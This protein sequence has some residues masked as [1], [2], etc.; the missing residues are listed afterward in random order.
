MESERF[1]DYT[2]D[3]RKITDQRYRKTL[4]HSNIAVHIMYD[5]LFGS[6]YAPYVLVMMLLL[7]EMTPQPQM[8]MKLVCSIQ[9][10]IVAL[11]QGFPLLDAL[12][13]RSWNV[14]TR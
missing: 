13:W 1:L 8:Q 9:A 7:S 14:V 5:D 3:E 4:Q 11:T 2:K 12:G 10:T 6:Q